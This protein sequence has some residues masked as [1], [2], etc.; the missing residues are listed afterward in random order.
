MSEDLPEGKL[1]G[2]E[3]V[4]YRVRRFYNLDANQDLQLAGMKE[5]KVR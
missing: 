1:T 2:S 4:F 3:I 5:G